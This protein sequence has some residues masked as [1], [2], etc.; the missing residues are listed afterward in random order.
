MTLVD[1]NVLLDIFTQTPGWWEW[2]L[3]QLEDAALEGPLLINDVIFAETSIR[4]PKIED[5]EQALL[6]AGITVAPIPRMALFLAGKASVQYRNAG[7]VRSS[8][9]P[10]FFIGAHAAVEK[11]PL[12]TRDTRR[13]RTY[14]PAVMLIAPEPSA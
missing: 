1:S 13:Y 6:D 2:S 9:L 3:A 10:D 4:F 5:F 14:F 12:L 8:V 11:L 7:G